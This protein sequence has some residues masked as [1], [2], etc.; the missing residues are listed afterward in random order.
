MKYV[1]DDPHGNLS[2]NIKTLDFETTD[3]MYDSRVKVKELVKKREITDQNKGLILD[4][5]NNKNKSSSVAEMYLINL[6]S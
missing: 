6:S 3:I 2:S 1:K 5:N 4:N